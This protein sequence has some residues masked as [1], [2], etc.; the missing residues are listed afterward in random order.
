MIRRGVVC[1]GLVVLAAFLSGCGASAGFVLVPPEVEK[2]DVP[3]GKYENV[4]AVYIYDIGF[5]HFDP[6]DIGVTFYPSYAYTRKARIKLL[7]RAATEGGHYGNIPIRH[8]RDELYSKKASVIKPDGTRVDLKGGDFITTILIK[9]VVPGATPPINFCETVII[10]PGLNPGDTIEYEYTMRGGYTLL[11]DFNK[12]DAPVMYSKYMAARPLRLSEIQPVIYDRH[13]L[14]PEK[15]IEKGIATGMMGYV[16]SRQATWDSWEAKE[17]P[18]ISWD[19]AMPSAVDL[20]SRVRIWQGERRWDWNVLGTTYYKWFTHYG[21]YPSKTGELA[22]EVT[23]GVVAP[24]ERA[25]AIHDW[26][27]KNLNIQQHYYLTFVPRQYEITRIDIDELLEEKNASPERAASL[28]WLMMQAVGVEA[29]LVL[30]THEDRPPAIQDLPDLYQF[31]HPLLALDDGTLI[32]TTNRLCPF[33]MVPWEYEGRKALWIKGESVSWRDMP[34]SSAADNSRKIEVTGEVGPDGSVKIEA[35]QTISGQMAYAWR[36]FYAPLKPKEVED[37]VRELITTT[38]DKAEVDE[39]T[40]N[41]IDDVDKPLELLVKYH[42]SS[43]ADLL[44]DRMVLKAGA[45]VHHTVCPILGALSATPTY[46][47]PKPMTESR[48]NPVK[49]PFRRY[50]E[51]DIKISFPKTMLLQALPK[52]FRTRDIEKGTSLGLQTSYGSEGGKNL[53]VVRKYSVN[54][55]Y[56]DLKGYPKLRDM[57]RRYEA[58]KDTLV[59]LELPKVE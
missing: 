46:I 13:S 41:N 40:F 33:G 30:A 57:I 50:D 47:C 14:E 59:T 58:Q 21:R 15:S 31:T 55:P 24:R 1:T 8:Y 28:M 26:V 52:G 25:K 12:V 32:D 4:H 48:D 22:K 29:T 35:K 54:E 34:K 7:T 18:P 5:V 3:E 43:Y 38:A 51:M 23:K 6:I 39:F 20:A 42:V 56:V 45:F 11:W 2:A 10:F 36:R 17:V 9:D 19:S 49:F 53:H 16:G 37:S 27:K 44:Q